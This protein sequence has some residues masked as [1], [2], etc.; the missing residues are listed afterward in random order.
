MSPTLA[1]CDVVMP[2]E[3]LMVVGDGSLADVKSEI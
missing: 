3:S 2:L 1:R